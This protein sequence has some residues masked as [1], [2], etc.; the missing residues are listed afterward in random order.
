MKV[1]VN[2]TV[3]FDVEQYRGRNGKELT[4]RQIKNII[5]N[6]ALDRILYEFGDEGIDITYQHNN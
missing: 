3:E 2:F 6:S 1:N 4:I 5:Q